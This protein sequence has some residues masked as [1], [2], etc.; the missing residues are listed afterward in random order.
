VTLPR[1]KAITTGSMPGFADVMGNLDQSDAAFFTSHDSW[2]GQLRAAGRKMV[3]YGD[4][5]WLRLSGSKPS[6]GNYFMR[7]EVV[8]GWLTSVSCI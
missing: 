1:I 5:T 8:N 4:D 3:L 2:L 6:D 7:S